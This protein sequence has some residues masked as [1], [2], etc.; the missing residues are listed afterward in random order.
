MPTI[1]LLPDDTVFTLEPG[2]FLTD[3]EFDYFGE[4]SIPFGCRAGAC[5]A[6]LVQ[7]VEGASG[8][9]TPDAEELDFI[10]SLGADPQQHRLACQCTLNADATLC[11]VSRLQG[12]KG[13]L[14]SAP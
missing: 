2:A 3:L 1:R 12:H 4:R 9:G 5:G 14:T 10:A 13:T 6:C 8:L 11:V 7:V